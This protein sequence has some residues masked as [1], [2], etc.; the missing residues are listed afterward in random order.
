MGV[1]P[2]M[3]GRVKYNGELT[4]LPVSMRTLCYSVRLQ[5][6][7]SI[8][9]R[10]YKAIAFDGSTAIIPKSQV[11]GE[12]YEAHKS[13]AY[14]ISAWILEKKDLQYS[15]KKKAWFNTDTHRFE[16]FVVIE[17]HTPDRHIPRPIQPSTE[18]VRP[19]SSTD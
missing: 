2:A 5:S 11:F 13:E 6:L 9:D 14:W 1:L 8:T 17:R 3:V 7:E 15:N 16:P 19:P 4:S 18:L 12:D 10:A